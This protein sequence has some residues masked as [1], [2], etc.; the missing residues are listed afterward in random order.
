MQD[1]FHV[2]FLL[3]EQHNKEL[4]KDRDSLRLEIFRLK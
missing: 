3:T 2:R 4:E 1:L